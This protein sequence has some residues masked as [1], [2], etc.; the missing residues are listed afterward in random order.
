M[1]RTIEERID[2]AIA[3]MLWKEQITSEKQVESILREHFA[4][5][6][7]DKPD[8]PGL[9]WVDNEDIE[10]F[11]VEVIIVTDSTARLIVDSGQH[12]WTVTQEPRHVARRWQ[13]AIG[14]SE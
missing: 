2:A 14:P 13:R 10:P 1:T 5:P 4:E 8:G 6:W 9:W 11:T 3:D 7:L 12:G